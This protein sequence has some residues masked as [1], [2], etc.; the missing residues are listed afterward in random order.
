[1]ALEKLASD[2]I[3]GVR[4]GV[5]RLIKL[6]CG[7]CPSSFSC[8][9]LPDGS[10][11]SDKHHPDGKPK[12]VLSAISI[13]SRDESKDVRGFVT[14][15]SQRGS[16]I[17]NADNVHGL[18]CDSVTTSAQHTFSRP[19]PPEVDIP[20]IESKP[21]QNGDGCNHVDILPSPKPSLSALKNGYDH[22]TK[23]GLSKTKDGVVARAVVSPRTKNGRVS[24]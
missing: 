14:A 21:T 20:P 7:K 15:I 1:M 11:D 19:P 23:A 10:L 12:W 18:K 4:I 6:I 16:T 5:A 8:W 22:E 24:R 2:H 3:P 13:L 9:V 17:P